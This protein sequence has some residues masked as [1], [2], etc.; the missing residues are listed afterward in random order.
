MPPIKIERPPHLME[1]GIIL[2]SPRDGAAPI[3][4]SKLFSG[5]L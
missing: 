4:V 2:L 5:L 1:E 3:N